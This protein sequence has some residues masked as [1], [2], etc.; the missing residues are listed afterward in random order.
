MFE[1]IKYRKVGCSGSG[2]RASVGVR[3][4]DMLEFGVLLGFKFGSYGKI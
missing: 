1:C 4:G 2:V 3:Q